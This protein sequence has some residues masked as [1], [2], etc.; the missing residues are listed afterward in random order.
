MLDSE[1]FEEKAKEGGK[2]CEANDK[3]W[4]MWEFFQLL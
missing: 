1:G 3:D 4:K 2:K